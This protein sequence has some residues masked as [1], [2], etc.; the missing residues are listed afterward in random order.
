M[1]TNSNDRYRR[2]ERA[3]RPRETN[4]YLEHLKAKEEAALNK[5]GSHLSLSERQPPRDDFLGSS[6]LYDDHEG[7]EDR[8]QKKGGNE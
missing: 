3:D 5:Y 1:T 7:L 8:I 6:V 2:T 4:G